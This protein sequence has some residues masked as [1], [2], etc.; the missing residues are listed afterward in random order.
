MEGR[1]VPADYARLH[2]FA[3]NLTENIAA[4]Q[5]DHRVLATLKAA[6]AVAAAALGLSPAAPRGSRPAFAV[7]GLAVV[8]Q[9]A[10]GVATLLR[11]VPLPLAAAHQAMAVL[12]LTAALWTLH[13]TRPAGRRLAPAPAG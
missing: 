8:A 6:A 3:L 5:F 10:L 13:R 4:V 12:V 9:Y 2:P 11:V 1:L 7:L